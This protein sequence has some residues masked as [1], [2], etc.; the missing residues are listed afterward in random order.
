MKPFGFVSD[1]ERTQNRLMLEA[2]RWSLVDAGTSAQQSDDAQG[3]QA[4][5]DGEE[6]WGSPFAE[7]DGIPFPK[8]LLKTGRDRR[9]A[10]KIVQKFRKKFEREHALLLRDEVPT[11]GKDVDRDAVGGVADAPAE[12]QPQIGATA[13]DVAAVDAGSNPATRATIE[14]DKAVASL[15]LS[16]SKQFATEE[17]PDAAL[18]AEPIHQAPV[19]NEDPSAASPVTDCSQSGVSAAQ[20]ADRC[21]ALEAE[22]VGLRANAQSLEARCAA[23]EEALHS[24][25]AAVSKRD[26]AL[27]LSQE[28]LDAVRGELYQ[29]RQEILRRKRRPSAPPVVTG[30][31][32]E[33][34]PNSGA[35]A[36]EPEGNDVL[37]R[38]LVRWA[39]DGTFG[40]TSLTDGLKVIRRLWPER[41]DIQPTAWESAADSADF[42]LPNKA[43]RLLVRLVTG[44]WEDMVSGGG[45]A[46]AR[47][48]F[49]A[50]EAAWNEAEG[51]DL[52]T[53]TFGGRIMVRHLKIGNGWGTSN[54]WRCHFDYDS[55]AERIVIGWCGRHLDRRG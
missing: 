45:D 15:P 38:M 3:R 4:S 29:A 6:A 23:L 2:L 44:Y 10:V 12:E 13:P 41:V 19:G 42:T 55:E 40:V 35:V 9:L 51:V 26:E 31:A 47:K 18:S 30:N 32:S 28:K 25:E 34:S 37:R 1:V 43:F 24:S 20:L 48:R 49:S 5:D 14:N 11:S 33:T 50:K 54:G 53:R 27:Q 7:I 16:D 46:V 22:A 21:A 39:E 8:R 17:P 36:T 52:T